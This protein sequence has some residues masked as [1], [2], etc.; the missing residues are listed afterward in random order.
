MREPECY[1]NE[2]QDENLINEYGGETHM[3]KSKIQQ[4]FEEVELYKQAV[5]DAK[6]ALASAEQELDETLDAEFHDQ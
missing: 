2:V 1:G 6:D 4:L 3:E 5:Q